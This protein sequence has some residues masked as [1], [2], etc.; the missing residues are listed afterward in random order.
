MI[1]VLTIDFGVAITFSPDSMF[2][3]HLIYAQKQL[4]EHRPRRKIFSRQGRF[5]AKMRVLTGS[6][7]IAH[8]R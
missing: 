6:V 1:S 3:L 5:Q 7:R 4:G 8:R 2:V